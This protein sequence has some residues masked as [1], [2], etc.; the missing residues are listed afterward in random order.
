MLIKETAYELD[1]VIIEDFFDKIL[2]E[3]E[4]QI[5]KAQ[6]CEYTTTKAQVN[7]IIRQECNQQC[8]YCYMYKF[9]DQLYPKHLTKEETIHNTHLILDYILQKKKVIPIIWELFAGDLFFDDLF[10]DIMD[11]IDEEFQKIYDVYPEIFTAN[12]KFFK[13]TTE[14]LII[15]PSNLRFVYDKPQVAEKVLKYIAYFREKYNYRIM[16]SWS[17]DGPYVADAREK[18]NLPEDY[19]D[20]LF[21]FCVKAEA[22]AHPMIAPENVKNW[23]ENFEWWVDYMA[24]LNKATNYEGDYAPMMLEVRNGYWTEENIADYCDLLKYMFDFNMAKCGNDPERFAYGIFGGPDIE[25]NP[26]KLRQYNPLRFIDNSIHVNGIDAPG[27]N[28]FTGLHFNVMD[29]SL[30]LCHRLTYKHLKPL[31]FLT[32]EDNTEIID[33]KPQ[34]VNAYI[35]FRTAKEQNLP[36]CNSCFLKNICLKGCFG[37]QFEDSGELFLPIPNVCNF[38]YHKYKTL[39]ELYEKYNIFNIALEKDYISQKFYNDC[40]EIKINYAR[41]AKVYGQ[42]EN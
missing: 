31:Y 6:K 13:D 5:F 30:E 23:K 22:G 21:D 32:N 12:Q 14:R 15:V 35:A 25:G 28:A 3:E 17:T 37:S 7:L 18:I 26:I 33:I 42:D 24:R 2:R 19:F 40:Q 1:K 10:F 9:G 11:A 36:M 20:V 39:I 8:E 4:E 41:G 29:L 27:C 34:N 16:F 38:F